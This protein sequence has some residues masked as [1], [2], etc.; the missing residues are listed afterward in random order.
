[1]SNFANLTHGVHRRGR[2]PSAL[3]QRAAAALAL[4][5]FSSLLRT[6]RAKAAFVF[7]CVFVDH[8]GRF[9]IAIFFP[10]PCPK[11]VVTT[12]GLR[13]RPKNSRGPI[14]AKR[15]RAAGLV[16]GGRDER[17]RRCATRNTPKG[18]CACICFRF[19]GIG[20]RPS[21]SAKYTMVQVPIGAKPTTLLEPCS[22][23]W[24]L[25]PTFRKI[26]EYALSLQPRPN[27]PEYWQIWRFLHAQISP[28]PLSS[29]V[30]GGAP[31]KPE[32][33]SSRHP[34]HPHHPPSKKFREKKGGT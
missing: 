21:A 13:P 16:Q 34:Q 20:S 24:R 3:Q 18:E 4:L 30:V 6:E 12:L 29:L 23:N 11:L 17:L 5:L 7:C 1:M 26:H 10:W 2:R 28:L 25:R 33:S 22:R 31:T 14:G 27:T 9:F 32:P 15:I 19:G 8:R